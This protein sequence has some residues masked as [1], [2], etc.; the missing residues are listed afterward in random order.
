MNPDGITILTYW[1][2]GG[3]L[4]IPLAAVC[5]FLMYFLLNGWKKISLLNHHI[6][7]DTTN[8]D[9]YAPTFRMIRNDFLLITALTG[10]A[11]LLGLSGTVAGMLHTFNAVATSGS[12]ITGQMASGIS[13]AL[14]TTQIGLVIAIPGLF[15]LSHLR[16]RLEQASIELGLLT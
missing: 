16:R 1:K 3:L 11:P 6:A 13:E 15:G 14:I 2:S 4:M 9:T 5:F 7:S 10:A 8:E 12:A